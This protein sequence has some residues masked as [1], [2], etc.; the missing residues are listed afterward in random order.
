MAT[1]KG[2]VQAF[3][4]KS[5]GMFSTGEKKGERLK[6]IDGKSC[7]CIHM[8]LTQKPHLLRI[9]FS[10]RT[11]DHVSGFTFFSLRTLQD[12]PISMCVEM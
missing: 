1:E 11:N 8:T 6:S 3:P 7:L 12:F 2:D 4:L 10:M 9:P 5:F